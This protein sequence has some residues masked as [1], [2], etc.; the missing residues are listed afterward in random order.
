[1]RR[2]IQSALLLLALAAACGSGRTAA[3]SLS[4]RS[5]SALGAT[6]ATPASGIQ[7][8][9]V[10][11]VLRKIELE[12]APTGAGEASQAGEVEVAAGPLVLDLSG[13]ALG[14]S[15]EHVLDAI[16][17]A[18]TYRE[19]KI[20][21]RAASASDAAA[22]GLADLAG[23]GASVLLEGTIDGNAFTFASS[24]RAAQKK[25][26]TFAVSAAGGSNLTLQLD[27]AGWFAGPGGARLDP[28]LESA[29]AAI[30]ANLA[31]SIDLFQDDN[32]SG[33]ENHHGGGDHDTDGGSD[34]AD[35]GVADAGCT[36]Y[37]GFGC[38][39]GDAGHGHDG[40]ADAGP[41][42]DGGGKHR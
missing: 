21:V 28:R 10:R 36:G 30:E 38:A 35:G 18:G 5:T 25:E 34:D 40:E 37:Y 27:P 11:L 4:A 16:V 15:V 23:R 14:G 2:I 7:L 22:P 31:S 26:G 6:A 12:P 42:A 1:M 9:R 8:D 32:R 17:P 29:R 3:L 41:E 33:H 20:E 19:L 13:A 24:L 39:A